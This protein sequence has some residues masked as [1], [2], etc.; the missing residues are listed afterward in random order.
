MPIVMRGR[1]NENYVLIWVRAEDNVLQKL[2][3]DTSEL[4]LE[5]SPEVREAVKKSKCVLED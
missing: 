2:Y 5:T 3:V 4:F 1:M